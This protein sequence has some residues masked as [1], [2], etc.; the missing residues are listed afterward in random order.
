MLAGLTP[1]GFHLDPVTGG[2]PVA[3][4]QDGLG[5]VLA[6]VGDS[7][8]DAEYAYGPFGEGVV[9]GAGGA[10]TVEWIGRDSDPSGLVQVRARYYHPG[11]GRFISPDP[12]GLAA[13]PTNPYLY[14]GDDPVNQ[15][16]PSGLIV[17]TAID[18]GFI[19]Y[20][21]YSLFTGGRK[22]A[23]A[24]L[25]ALSLDLAGALI[26]FVTGLGAAARAANKLDGAAGAI[27]RSF[28][29]SADEWWH[30]SNTGPVRPGT[31][32]P[33]SFDLSVAGQKFSVH[34]NATKHMAE[35]AATTGGGYVP[36]SS[37]AGSVEAAVAQGLKAG[38]NFGTIG[39]WELGID[40]S[41]NVI[42]HALYRP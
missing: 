10:N 14:A 31:L 42:Y 28:M 18:A 33:L 2:D 12:L 15:A 41:S 17:D 6:L 30:A 26:P 16:D 24:N 1:A 34:P 38:R 8:A 4:V 9:D 22:N 11:L 39:Q 35:Y 21:L 23:A 5:S 3:Y 32:V 7:G 25:G 36:I 20:D 29:R 37:L 40:T 19:A 27:G 13:G